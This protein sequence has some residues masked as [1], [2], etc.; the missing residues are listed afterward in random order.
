MMNCEQFEKALAADPGRMPAG[1]DE[2]VAGCADCRALRDEYR[3][4][5]Q[6]I[7]HA[8]A[9]PVPALRMPQLEEPGRDHDNIALLPVRRRLTAPAW[10]GIA[11]TVALAAWLGLLLQK[12]DISHLSLAQQVIA[13]LDHE[14]SSRVIS[15]VSVSERTLDSVVRKEVAE[16]DRGIGLI[17]YARS[18]VIN[19]KSVPHLVVQGKNG[20]ITL[21]LMPDEPVAAATP[22]EGHAVSGVILPV[23]NGSIAIIAERGEPLQEIEQK[24][25]DSIKWK[26]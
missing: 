13:H 26:T 19:G 6:R 16:L 10:F 7:A 17:S 12:P 23:G 15:T 21:L 20:P 22:L 14:T 11:A 5:E 4:L 18:C 1:G 3:Q 2:H 25:V 8:L 24:I 9:V